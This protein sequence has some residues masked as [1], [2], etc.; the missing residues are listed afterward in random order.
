VT[1]ANTVLVLLGYRAQCFEPK[2]RILPHKPADQAG[3]T[4]VQTDLV[5]QLNPNTVGVGRVDGA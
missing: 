2:G 4:L 1:G 3:P 5:V